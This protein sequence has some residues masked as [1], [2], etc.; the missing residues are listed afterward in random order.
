MN[1]LKK[2]FDLSPIGFQLYTR[3]FLNNE[4]K[5]D[6]QKR[7]VDFKIKENEKVLDVGCGDIPFPYA[8]HMADRFPEDTHHRAGK[9]NTN[10]KPFTQADVQ[11]LPF[12]NQSFDFVYCS[13]LLEHVENP[14]K[15]MDELMRVGK[16]G[17]IEVPTR[18]SDIV[19]NFARLKHFHKWYVNKLENTLIFIEYNQNDLRDTG[20]KEFFHMGHSYIP[21][22][23]R[24]TSRKN[25][26]LY[27]NMF[28]WEKEFNYY[29]FDKKGNIIAQRNSK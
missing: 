17:Y 15:A 13:H 25:K 22:A 21:N 10:D 12:E 20:D 11:D 8:T 14:A 9:L 23:F 18:M 6:Y 1:L 4:R 27:T 26:D 24:K 29:V 7:Y 19:F 28:L 16:R 5:I 3:K 2:I